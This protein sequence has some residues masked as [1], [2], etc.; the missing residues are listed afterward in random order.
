MLSEHYLLTGSHSFLEEVYPFIAAKA[1]LIIKMRHTRTPIKFYNEFIT[2][3]WGLEPHLEIMCAPAR[4]GWVQGRMDH[5][6]PLYWVNGFC[7][8]GLV[9]AAQCAEELGLDG[10][11][12]RDEAEQLQAAMLAHAP[13][14]F[15][16]N[17]RDLVC[18]I[19]PT[20]WA[21]ADDALIR[22]RFDLWWDTVRYPQGSH[23]PERLWTYFEIGTAHNYMRL[24]QR[25][26]TWVSLDYALDHHTAPGLYTWPEGEKDEN[27]ALLLWERT[28]GWDRVDFVTP[29]GWT[30][31]EMFLLLRNCLAREDGDTLVLGEGIPKAWMDVS[32]QV[33]NLPTAFGKLSYRYHAPDRTVEVQIE[34]TPK[35]WIRAAFPIP[36]D[37]QIAATAITT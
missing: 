16:K 23:H 26:R 30:G 10:S 29:A 18:A 4:D 19:W 35:N 25:E 32:F 2:S 17:E 15:G 22:E 34:R 6:Y 14:L 3:E 33:H 11:R 20:E 1:D 13:A 31:A 24:G 27:S 37:V 8:L 5:H 21:S 7:Y 28:R 9:R 36:V 12:Y